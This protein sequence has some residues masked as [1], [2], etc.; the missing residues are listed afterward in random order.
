MEADN[1]LNETELMICLK[2]QGYTI[3][4]D[5]KHIS[6]PIECIFDIWNIMQGRDPSGM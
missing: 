2:E 6:F 3:T 1:K 5:G 4:L